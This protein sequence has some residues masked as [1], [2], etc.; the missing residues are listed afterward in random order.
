MGNS[1]RCISARVVAAFVADDGEISLWPVVARLWA[2][3]VTVTVPAIDDA[4][5]LT[6]VRWDRGVPIWG[7]ADSGS[8]YRCDASRW[9]CSATM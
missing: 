3:G 8:P 5:D 9:R 6:F 4:D 2:D 7:R 1:L